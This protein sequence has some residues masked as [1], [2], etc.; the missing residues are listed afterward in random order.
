LD[1]DIDFNTFDRKIVDAG[2][3]KLKAGGTVTDQTHFDK[4]RNREG[5]IERYFLDGAGNIVTNVENAA[6]LTFQGYSTGNL[7]LLGIPPTLA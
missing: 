5:D 7:L 3:R 6:T 4:I 2:T 1:F